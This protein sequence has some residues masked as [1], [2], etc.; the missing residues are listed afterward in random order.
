MERHQTIILEE[1]PSPGF[2]QMLDGTMPLD[3]YLLELDSGFPEFDRQMHRLLIELHRQGKRILQVEP[4]LERLLEIHELFA[5]GET[6]DAVLGMTE[7]RD[8]YL[9]EKHATGSLISFYALS[10]GAPF[11]EVVAGVKHFARADAVR[12]VLRERLRARAVAG[13]VRPGD[14]TYVEAGYIHY[15]LYRF[16]R[17]EMGRRETIRVV[18]LL[19]PVVRK[20]GGKR[21]NLG[22]GDIL[23]LHYAF[24]NKLPEVSARLLAARSLIYIKLINKEELLPGEIEAPHSEDEVMVNRIVDRLDF[25]QCRALFDRIRL[26]DRRTALELTR[27]FT[28]ETM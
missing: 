26:A 11:E 27:A 25:E 15:P 16:L 1:P 3:D 22:P 24:D 4:Y 6:P 23:T 7:L 18:F 14:S 9:A 8:V 17:Q 5:D 20:L 21:R 2:A 28:K 19:D 13:L 10:M 12:L